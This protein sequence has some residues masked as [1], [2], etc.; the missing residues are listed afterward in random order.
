MNSHVLWECCTQQCSGAGNF[1]GNSAVWQQA[2]LRQWVGVASL[3][4]R[5]K[6]D[7]TDDIHRAKTSTT[8][9]ALKLSLKHP[10]TNALPGHTLD[11]VAVEFEMGCLALAGLYATFDL[12]PGSPRAPTN[13]LASVAAL[14]HGPHGASPGQPLQRYWTY[15]RAHI[16][17][18]VAP[19]TGTTN[20]DQH[21]GR[22]AKPL[23]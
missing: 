16:T 13:A 10:L 11:G 7:M 3:L 20:G 8:S 17:D 6:P 19:Q 1:Q 21:S 23:C 2:R 4:W 18:L 22:A 9:W 14:L 12:G 15:A 5:L